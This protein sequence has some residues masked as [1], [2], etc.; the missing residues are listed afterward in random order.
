MGFSRQEHWS[1]VPNGLK[2][3]QTLGESE[4]QGRLVCCSPWSFRKSRT[5]LSRWTI[6]KDILSHPTVDAK[7]PGQSKEWGRDSNAGT[8]NRERTDGGKTKVSVLLNPET[9]LAILS[10][11]RSLSSHAQLVI[12]WPKGVRGAPRGGII[13]QS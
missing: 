4:G 13:H 9:G 3:E 2:F 7:L 10:A 6:T 11:S 5:R 1:G 12:L 8:D